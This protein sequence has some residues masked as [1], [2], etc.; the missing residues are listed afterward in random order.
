MNQDCP[1]CQIKNK[2]MPAK[3]IYEEDN[4]IAFEDINPMA[5]IHWLIIPKKHYASLNEVSPKDE[6]LLGHLLWVA[7]H[8]AEKSGLKKTGYR[9]V[10][11]TGPNSGQQIAHLHLHLLGGR[12]FSWPPG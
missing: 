10:I 4:L 11:N 5:P 2:Q 1:F 3:I 9:L 12:R 8:L 6:L 7:T